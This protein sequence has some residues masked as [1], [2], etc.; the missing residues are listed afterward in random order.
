MST[1][2]DLIL[3]RFHPDGTLPQ[4]PAAVWVFG[5]NLEGRHG[6]GAA[7]VAA[8]RYAAT[9]FQSVGRMGR[10]YAIPTKSTPHATL[11]LPVIRTYIEE[12][13]RYAAA[14]PSETYFVTRIG[15]GEA[16]Y[17]DEQVAPLFLG[18]PA[19]CDFAEDW[20]LYLNN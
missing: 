3:Y 6:K 1:M 4:S 18:S 7:R 14:H 9:R 11:T 20:R 16:G 5:S 19:N 10:C 2:P 13:K 15:C 8:D 17:R 12:F